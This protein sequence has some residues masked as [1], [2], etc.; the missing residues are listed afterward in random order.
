VP[1][2]L[3]STAAADVAVVR[4]L[5][6]VATAA[7][8]QGVEMFVVDFFT[9]AYVVFVKSVAVVNVRV[10]VLSFVTRLLGVTAVTRA[11]LSEATIVID[12]P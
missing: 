5:Q 6:E 10:V 12:T 7:A 11:A 8:G 2:P 1:A 9:Q 3:T 4:S